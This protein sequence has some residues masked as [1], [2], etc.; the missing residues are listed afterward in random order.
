MVIFRWIVV[1]DGVV[2]GVSESLMSVV[3]L[4]NH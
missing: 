1:Y 2:V 4:V 3:T